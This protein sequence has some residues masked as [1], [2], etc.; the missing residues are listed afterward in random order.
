LKRSWANRLTLLA[1]LAACTPPPA[2]ETTRFA[3]TLADIQTHIEAL[4]RGDGAA[5]LVELPGT[6]DFLQFTADGEILQLGFPVI[7]PRQQGLES[8]LRAVAA[9]LGLSVTDSRGTD[10]A[11]FVDIELRGPEASSAIAR[12]LQELY[13]VTE[14]SALRFICRGCR[15][16]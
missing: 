14:Q 3:G 16:A 6:E 9:S 8:D 13:G 2:G 5:L 15:A 12:M 1:G 11:R 10:G 7:T 4:R